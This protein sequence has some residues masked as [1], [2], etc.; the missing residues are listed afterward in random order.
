MTHANLHGFSSLTPL[1]SPPPSPP[2]LSSRLGASLID[3]IVGCVCVFSASFSQRRQKIALFPSHIDLVESAGVSFFLAEFNPP[4]QTS[5]SRSD[6]K[7]IMSSA[8][9]RSADAAATQSTEE[10]LQIC[11]NS[12]LILWKVFFFKTHANVFF[13]SLSIFRLHLPSKNNKV[14]Q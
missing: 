10:N 8:H 9:S 5:L 14:L 11:L 2:P 6:R 7:S 4:R 3:A 12:A 1:L 13:P